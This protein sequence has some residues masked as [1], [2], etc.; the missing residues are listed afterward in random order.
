MSYDGISGLLFSLVLMDLEELYMTFGCCTI[1]YLFIH[2]FVVVLS[3]FIRQL[4]LALCRSF[5]SIFTNVFMFFVKS[6]AEQ[7]LAHPL[8]DLSWER[9]VLGREKLPICL[10][11]TKTVGR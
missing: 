7:F 8:Q 6:S 10:K 3:I 2:S 11:G 5:H 1:I 4:V 9:K